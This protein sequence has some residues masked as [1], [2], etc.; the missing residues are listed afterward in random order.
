MIKSLYTRVVLVFVSIVMVSLVTAF[1]LATW[2]YEERA[3]GIVQDMLLENGRQMLAAYH[4]T[5]GAELVPFMQHL[6]GLSLTHT[7]L[8]DAAGNPLLDGEE[9]P[10]DVE[11]ADV[12][13]VLAG[14]QR[15]DLQRI[16][17]ASSHGV[18]LPVVGLPVQVDGQPYALFVTMKRNKADEELMDSIHVMYALILFI[19]SF[20][21]VVAARYLVKPIVQLT[22]AT[23]R[24]AKG[25]FAVE[26]PGRR[27]DE[28][29]ILS[30][31]FNQMAKELA[32][33]D[34]MRRDFVS[35]V[36]HE[37]GSPL[38]SISG[39]TKALK[40]KEVSEE[41][42]LRY[43]TIIEEESE[44]LSRLSQNLLQLSRLQQD[45]MPLQTRTY[46]LDE[47]LRKVV[48]ALAPQWEAKRIDIDLHLQPLVIEADEDQLSQ[49]WINLL[50]NSIK[51]TPAD[52]TI[53]IQA[54]MQDKMCVVTLSDSGIGIPEEE[55]SHIFQPFYKVDKA[56]HSAVKGNGLGLSIVKQIIDR[57]HGDIRVRGE[58]GTG[59]TFDITLPQ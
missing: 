26:V 31:S 17:T 9:I 2:L 34:Q 11:A 8:Y 57:H 32:V 53:R 28:I 29:G 45:N 16:D 35:N 1:F 23:R 36:S 18:S 55:R 22:E 44:R 47:Q 27:K 42:R 56:R 30:A 39:F 38:T 5:P 12:A 49:V 15:T 14:E 4:S 52:G 50:S 25:E 51:F 6:S 21:I 37:I 24:M 19:G 10:L 59:A 40:Q 20:L 58:A 54:A 41:S 48:I 13:R 3:K 33:L 46:R 43:L 7:Q